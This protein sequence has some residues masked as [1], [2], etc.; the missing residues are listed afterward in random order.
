ML[1]PEEQFFRDNTYAESP[2][3]SEEQALLG[4][5]LKKKYLDLYT[6][7]QPDPNNFTDRYTPKA[8]NKDLHYVAEKEKTIKKER[9]DRAILAE[10][11]IYYLIDRRHI[12][13]TDVSAIPASRYDDLANGVD[14]I[15]ETTEAGKQHWVAVDVTV[16]EDQRTIEAKQQKISDGLQEG[17]FPRV[18][19]FQ[20]EP[21]HKG[22]VIIPKVVITLSRKELEAISRILVTQKSD[23]PTMRKLQERFL[24]DIWKQLAKGSIILHRANREKE[25]ELSKKLY[26]EYEAA[27]RAF[28]PQSALNQSARTPERPGRK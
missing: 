20:S 14:M 21:Y 15:I 16:A 8:I 10:G 11:L 7:E 9:H 3:S 19:Y 23:D 13:G 6:D 18:K 2:L 27:I 26:E 1:N 17:R 5:D 28:S 22:E 12:L 24:L 25:Q 4:G